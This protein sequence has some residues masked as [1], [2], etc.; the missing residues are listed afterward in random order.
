VELGPDV[1]EAASQ[2]PALR[3]HPSTTGAGAASEHHRGWAATGAS[4]WRPGGLVG[5]DGTWGGAAETRGGAAET[6]G[7]AGPPGLGTGWRPECW[8]A[9]A[10]WRAGG[11]VYRDGA[12]WC[13]V[14]DQPVGNPKRKV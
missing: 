3:L 7:G 8:P 4:R 10:S 13:L 11:V 9:A 14:N 6:R 1:R 2:P 5:G 12:G